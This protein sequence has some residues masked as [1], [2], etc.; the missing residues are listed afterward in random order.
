M[1][2][3]GCKPMNV[4]YFT[5]DLF[6]SVAATSIVSL[7]E[8]NKTANEITFYI[9]DD[10]ITGENKEKLTTM[11]ASYGRTVRYIVAPDPSE[12]F[13]FPFKSRYQMG[14]SY[15]RMAIGTLLPETVDRV[16]ALDSD[17]LITGDITELWNLDMGENILAGVAD[18]MNLKA[19]RR[20]FGLSGEEFYCNAGVFLI[21][22]KKWREQKVEEKIKNVI[23]KKNG[24]VFFFEQTLMNYSCKGKIY[25]LH[26]KY[27]CYT[28]FFA[29]DYKNLIR[30]RKPTIFYT[31][32]EVAEAKEKSTIIHFTR[33]FYMLSRP[34]VKGCDHPVSLEYQN[35]KKLTAWPNLD[36]DTRT[37]KQLRKY[38][39]WHAFPQGIIARG[40]SVLYNSIRPRMWWKNE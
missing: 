18:C 11:I 27:N 16:I 25:K 28:L 15:V 40:A 6:A 35:Y 17:T 2:E 29:F 3:R 10:G 13:D 7:L 1:N 21:D 31:E 9:I 36:D 32:K 34:W 23:K 22:L 39:L 5:S 26:P 14:H 30:W 33:N 12:L 4:F 37:G 38:R 20:Q 24:N 8:N 19:Y